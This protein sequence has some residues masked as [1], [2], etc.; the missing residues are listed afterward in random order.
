MKKA[1]VFSYKYRLI[2][3]LIGFGLYQLTFLSVILLNS[4]GANSVSYQIYRV[5]SAP[6]NLLPGGDQITMLLT[7]SCWGSAGFLL[8]YVQDRLRVAKIRTIWKSDGNKK[9]K[10]PYINK[11]IKKPENNS[12]K[13]GDNSEHW[14]TKTFCLL[15]V[16]FCMYWIL[17]LFLPDL[18]YDFLG[19][20]KYTCSNIESDAQNTLA[21]LAAYFSEPDKDEVPTLQ[22]L[23]RTENLILHKFSTVLIDGPRDRLRITVIDN[24][25]KCP[26]GKKYVVDMGGTSG[27]WY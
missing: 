19:V 14:A 10:N 3:S 12:K 1:G 22:D 18:G 20:N 8:G 23:V 16:A 2:Y 27:T 4:I 24:K 6:E 25:R 5:I 11:I 26:R 21:A 15:W 7:M 9:F 17:F 13:K